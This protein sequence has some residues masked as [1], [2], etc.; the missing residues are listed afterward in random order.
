MFNQAVNR[1]MFRFFS[2]AQ[3][4]W[5]CLFLRSPPPKKN[6]KRN[7]HKRSGFSF[8]F[9]FKT[10]HQ[11]TQKTHLLFPSCGKGAEPGSKLFHL[12]GCS[13]SRCP[14]HLECHALRFGQ[15][16]GIQDMHFLRQSLC[17]PT[18]KLHAHRGRLLFLPLYQQAT[19]IRPS[20]YGYIG[21]MG[22]TVG[23]ASWNCMCVDFC[24]S[25][26]APLQ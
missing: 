13:L 4:I 23:G 5:T 15:V 20:T 7:R 11:G 9:P 24:D 17:F 6:M 14:V 1:P 10:I 16:I 2:W 19:C 3:G 26:E 8:W 21:D 22:P 12:L 18:S 25:L